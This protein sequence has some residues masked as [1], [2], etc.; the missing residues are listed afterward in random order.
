MENPE[1]PNKGTENDDTESTDS[2]LCIIL[3]ED[4]EMENNI[5]IPEGASE[6]EGTSLVGNNCADKQMTQNENEQTQITQE[7]NDK[8]SFSE[9]TQS[10]YAQVWVL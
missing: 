4:L 2:S 1:V 3:A 6:I 8:D 7:D 10:Q 5:K 9:M